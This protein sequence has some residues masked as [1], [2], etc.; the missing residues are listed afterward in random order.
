[1]GTTPQL[2]L[3]G[4]VL[5]VRV[6]PNTGG[7]LSVLWLA[8]VVADQLVAVSVPLAGRGVEPRR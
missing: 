3:W 5:F 6:R 7:L 4:V 2:T 1:M 8:A